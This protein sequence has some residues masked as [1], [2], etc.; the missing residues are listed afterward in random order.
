MFQPKAVPLEDVKD[1]VIIQS[2]TCYER[3]KGRTCSSLGM[4]WG[5]WAPG[6]GTTSRQALKPEDTFIRRK[7]EKSSRNE[8]TCAI[9]CS[10]NS[11]SF[12]G[13]GTGRKGLI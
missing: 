4:G 10:E 9:A 11:K 12:H 7:R 13:M 6:G 2:D 3:N 1:C 8:M 5:E